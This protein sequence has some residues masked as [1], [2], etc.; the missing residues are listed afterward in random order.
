MRL[1]PLWLS[2]DHSFS[3][4]LHSFRLQHSPENMLQ[5]QRDG[6]SRVLMDLGCQAD[7]AGCHAVFRHLMVFAVT[8][9][10]CPVWRQR[11]QFSAEN[12][13]MH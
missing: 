4:F 13:N 9:C 6:I 12:N 1:M 11:F 10:D 3:V 8:A 2:Q 7:L 5:L